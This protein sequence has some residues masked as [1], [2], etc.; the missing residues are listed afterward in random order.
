M[1]HQQVGC[2]QNKRVMINTQKIKH[3]STV[4][5]NLC[6]YQGLIFLCT[7][8]CV[9]EGRGDWRVVGRIAICQRSCISNPSKLYLCFVRE[10]FRCVRGQKKNSASH[11]NGNQRGTIHLCIQCK[12]EAN[13]KLLS[14]WTTPKHLS[15]C[16]SIREGEW[17]S[18]VWARESD[19]FWVV[20]SF[21]HFL[22]VWPWDSSLIILCFSF[23]I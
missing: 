8:W 6:R 19:F 18:W 23:S 7:C 10:F 11:Q 12:E 13:S 1:M 5:G 2:K 14:K 3:D 17:I 4:R 20:A 22:G 16:S 15:A 9:S 21:C